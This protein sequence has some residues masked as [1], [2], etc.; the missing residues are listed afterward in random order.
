[1][2]RRA[3]P[4]ILAPVPR[5]GRFM[6]LALRRGADPERALAALASL[7]HLDKL[8]IGLGTP[9]FSAASQAIPGLR[10]FPSLGGRGVSIPS[11]QE[12]VWIFVSGPDAGTVLIEARRVLA[13]LA[14]ALELVEDVAS[15]MFADSRDL[16]GYED[17]TENP[18]GERATAAAIVSD[19]EDGL[20]GSSFVAVER[21]IHDLD[22][23]ARLSVDQRDAIIGRR[24]SDNEEI[25]DAPPSAHVKRTAQEN[26]DPPAF[27]L[28]R[29]M[30]W[31]D[32]REHGLY[33]VAYGATLDAFE[34]A[35]V[36]MTGGEDGIADGLFRFSRPV[37]G[38]YYWCPPRNGEHL[39]LRAVG[40]EAV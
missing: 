17:G 15:F 37:T 19:A 24:L 36:R 8:V 13:A 39:D 14:D 28:R 1:M 31:G 30:P 11:T 23:L 5:A 10:E 22:A 21:W 34:R 18:T 12:A 32:I 3:Q 6:T 27:M 29:S 40:V 20:I 33:F 4:A 7:T 35:L 16:S 38:G 2:S 26:F 25:E 9:L